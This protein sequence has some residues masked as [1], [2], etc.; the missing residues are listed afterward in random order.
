MSDLATQA[1]DPM[2]M[3]DLLYLPEIFDDIRDRSVA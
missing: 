1:R 2:A 3:P